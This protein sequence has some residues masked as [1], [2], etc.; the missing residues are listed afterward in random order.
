MKNVTAPILF[1]H[2]KKDT[3]VPF[4]HSEEMYAAAHEPKQLV[5]L[6]DCGHNDMGV[7]NTEQFQGAIKDFIQRSSK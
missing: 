7:Q 6:N 5:L 4:Q 1:M 3:I 2:G